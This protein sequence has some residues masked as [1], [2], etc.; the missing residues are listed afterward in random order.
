MGQAGCIARFPIV[1][2]TRAHTTRTQ[3]LKHSSHDTEPSKL[4]PPRPTRSLG[5]PQHDQRRFLLHMPEG[6][7][8][9]GYRFTYVCTFANLR[10]CRTPPCSSQ[11]NF[12]LKQVNKMEVGLGWS[13][14]RSIP[15]QHSSRELSLVL[16]IA[17]LSALKFDIRV[18]IRFEQTN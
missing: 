12:D 4:Y 16:Q 3:P 5:R 15:S 9:V 10:P 13:R 2:L 1:S 14:A 18:S 7:L 11:H 6:M 8:C 17:L